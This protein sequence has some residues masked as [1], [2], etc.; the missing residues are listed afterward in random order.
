MKKY[1]LFFAFIFAWSFGQAQVAEFDMLE[2]LFAQ[3]RYKMVYRK[4]GRLLDKPE[5]DYSLLP[6]YYRSLSTIKLAQ[7]KF[8]KK[9]HP[10]ALTDVKESFDVIKKS[11]HNEAFLSAHIY[12]LEWMRSDMRKW[13]S[14]LKSSG[15]TSDLKQIKA[16]IVLMFDGIPERNFSDVLTVSDCRMALVFEAEKH[17]GTPYVWA[18]TTPS[19]FDCSGFVKY[20]MNESG[21]LLPRV[22]ADQYKDCK[23]LKR[24][25]VRKGDLIFFSNNNSEV[26]H[27]GLVVSELGEPLKMIHSSSSKGIILTEIDTSIYWS[28]RLYGFGTFIH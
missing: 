17:I 21:V 27:V 4:S 2:M 16:L 25:H 20:V 11:K 23:K 15:R 13:V 26:S 7:N 18:G 28:K 12:E 8:W 19:G 1:S 6:L 10:N 3:Q 24:K 5:Y 9:Y 22:A 14:S